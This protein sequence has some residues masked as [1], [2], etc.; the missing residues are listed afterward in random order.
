[1]LFESIITGRGAFNNNLDKKVGSWL[2]ERPHPSKKAKTFKSRHQR[3]EPQC[4]IELGSEPNKNL[5]TWR[6]KGQS[7]NHVVTFQRVGVKN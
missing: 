6:G 4:Y 2:V 7:I 5:D 1:M 3:S